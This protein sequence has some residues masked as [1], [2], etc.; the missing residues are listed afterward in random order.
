MRGQSSP[1]HPPTRAERLPIRK[2]PFEVATKYLRVA[3]PSEKVEKL[4]GTVGAW[5]L[6]KTFSWGLGYF[7]PNAP[8]SLMPTSF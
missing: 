7:N 5:L 4:L 6:H 8:K 1:S 2:G 3:E